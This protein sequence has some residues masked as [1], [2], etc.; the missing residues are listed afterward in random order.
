MSE[1]HL[2]K[3]SELVTVRWSMEARLLQ[4]PPVTLLAT[5]SVC[6]T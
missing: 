5:P 1:W 3:M 2:V 6:V 4:L